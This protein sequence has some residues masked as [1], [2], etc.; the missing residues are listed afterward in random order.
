GATRAPDRRIRIVLI[1]ENP[2]GSQPVSI[3]VPSATGTATLERLQAP[4]LYSHGGVT[5]GGQG[6]G[7]STSTGLPAG[8]P[9]IAS[10]N[11][12]ASGYTVELPAASAALLSVPSS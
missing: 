11:P 10:V 7:S 4:S 5:L 6:F 1:N 3:R 8:R 9:R 12:G 2:S